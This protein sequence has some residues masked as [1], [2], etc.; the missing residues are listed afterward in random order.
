MSD[1]VWRM[2]Y[3]KKDANGC[4]R[5]GIATRATKKELETLA[6]TLGDT[7]Y[8]IDIQKNNSFDAKNGVQE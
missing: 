2:T 7:I 4:S 8:N 1:K 5:R 3:N 6:N